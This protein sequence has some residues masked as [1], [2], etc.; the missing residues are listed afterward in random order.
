[1]VDRFEEAMEEYDDIGY[2]LDARFLIRVLIAIGTGQSRFRYLTEFWKTP[3]EEIELLW[4]R[5]KKAVDSAVNFVRHNARFEASDWL[6]SLMPLVPLAAYFD[7][8]DA[9]APDVERG[10]LRWF[11]IASLRGRYSASPETKLDDDLR[12]VAS[13][14][15][16]DRLMENAIPPGGSA[17][18]GADE[19]D[20][21][22]VRNPLFPMT[23]A[24]ARRRQAKDWFT[25]ITLGTDVVG[26]DHDIQVHHVFPKAL[27]KQAGVSRRDRDEIANLAFLAARPN[28][29]ISM[30]PPDAYLTE[31]ADRHPERLEA[32]CIPMSRDLW[33]LE[34]FQDFLAVRREMLSKAVN[35]LVAEPL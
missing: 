8:H 27:L 21:A 28:R 15:P 12:A 25:G 3:S 33:R 19:L 10:L 11:Y 1:V 23:Y 31:I 16:I 34:R 2:Q 17:E 18:V 35:D 30:R 4:R 6:P 14:T 7:R 22:G 13:G 29:K 20:D 5:S 26:D 24:V 32:Q 9:I